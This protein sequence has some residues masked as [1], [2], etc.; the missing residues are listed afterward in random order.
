MSP[1]AQQAATRYI[2]YIIV[3]ST[4]RY[5]LQLKTPNILKNIK[6]KLFSSVRQNKE[7]VTYSGSNPFICGAGAGVDPNKVLDSGSAT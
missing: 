6:G 2:L 4:S 7:Y 1:A 3:N 5:G